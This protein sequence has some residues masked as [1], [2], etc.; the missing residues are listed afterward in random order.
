MLPGSWVQPFS[1]EKIVEDRDDSDR[2]EETVKIP[3]S[4]MTVT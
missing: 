3:E 4:T 2:D 1:A